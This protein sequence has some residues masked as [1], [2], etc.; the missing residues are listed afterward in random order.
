MPVPSLDAFLSSLREANLLEPSVIEEF[1]RERPGK[2]PD[3]ETLAEELT[4]RGLLTSYQAQQLLRGGKVRLG[5]YFLLDRLGRGG[6]GEVFLARHHSLGRLAAVKVVRGE[7]LNHPET[8]RRFRRESLAAAR[9]HHPNV[10]SAYDGGEQDD[11]HYLAM[12]YLEGSDLGRLLRQR[13]ALPAAEA[14]E[15]VRQALLGLHHAHQYGLVHRDL[16]PSNLMLTNQDGRPV[17]K[18][19]DFG[20]TRFAA[21]ADEDSSLTPSGHWLGTPEFVSPEQARDGKHVDIRSD[22]FSLGCTLFRLL[23]DRPAFPGESPADRMFA[24]LAGEATRLCDVNPDL[25]VRLEAVV[26]R[27]L[28]RDPADRYQTPAEAADALAPF[29]TAADLLWQS[30]PA[31]DGIAGGPQSLPDTYDATGTSVPSA[32]GSTT[33]RVAPPASHKQA[34]RGPLAAVVGL[35]GV[36][37]LLAFL[38]NAPRGEPPAAAPEKYIVNSVGMKLARVPA[39]RFL[40][41]S[42]PAEEGRAEDEGP[43]REVKVQRPYYLGAHEV[44]QAEYAVVMDASPSH[45]AKEGDG[46]AEVAGADTGR[47]PVEMVSWED[48][49]AFCK[50]LTAR[51]QE[52]QAGR[53]YRLPTEA[54]WEHACRAGTATPFHTGAALGALDANVHGLR[55]LGGAV[56]RPLWMHT[57]PVGAYPANAFGLHDMHGNVWEWCEDRYQPYPGNVRAGPPRRKQIDDPRVLRGGGWGFAA[58][59]CRSA[60]RMGQPPTARTSFFGFRVACDVPAGR[61]AK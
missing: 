35:A 51:P 36:A 11:V 17:V 2:A 57:V 6:M 7:R 31:R 22:V 16:K 25:S 33:Y 3:A 26:A 20:L 53:V 9:L 37:G 56:L 18:V 60:A 5:H 40:M 1:T 23:T 12:E 61:A 10:V 42:P 38:P 14:C 43:Q 21:E 48:A 58:A 15:Y 29:C 45:F 32:T 50:A 52:R 27:M 8:L 54:E 30:A 39:G 24:R 49:K 44:T 28:A 46:A 19:L 47:H 59:E 4:R 13:G 34:R 55:P 41:G